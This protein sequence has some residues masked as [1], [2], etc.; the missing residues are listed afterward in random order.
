M[1]G[2]F[3]LQ[4]LYTFMLFALLGYATC[5]TIFNGSMACNGPNVHAISHK[6][7]EMDLQFEYIHIVIH[8]G[9][10]VVVMVMHGPQ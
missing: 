2:L 3:C 9:T 1:S 6:I 7:N 10:V 8:D 4:F 5:P